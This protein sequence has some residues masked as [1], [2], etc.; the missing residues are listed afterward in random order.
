M[1]VK[2]YIIL[3]LRFILFSLK[4]RLM[5]PKDCLCFFSQRD[6]TCPYEPS[7]GY[8][9][10]TSLCAG[11]A[12]CGCLQCYAARC[13]DLKGWTCAPM[14]IFITAPVLQWFAGSFCS[15][16]HCLGCINLR[17]WRSSAQC[18]YF[19]CFDLIAAVTN[20]QDKP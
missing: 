7:P 10:F 13:C 8:L 1:M 2:E 4:I 15:L 14:T 3:S 6:N 12:R 9:T 19:Q 11:A 20:I 18:N 17:P 16:S 5:C